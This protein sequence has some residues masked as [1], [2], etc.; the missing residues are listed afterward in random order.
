MYSE[1]YPISTPFAISS[2]QTEEL[3][4]EEPAVLEKVLP[5][6]PFLLEAALLQDTGRPRVMADD[7][8]DDLGQTNSL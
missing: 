4:I 1:A 6:K 8:G 3:R 5:Q 2:Q 7:V